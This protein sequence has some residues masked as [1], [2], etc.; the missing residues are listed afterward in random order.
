MKKWM[1]ITLMSAA[2]MA[3][4][5]LSGCDSSTNANQSKVKTHIITAKKT[6]TTSNLYYKGTIEPINIISA[7]SPV[8]GR[9]AKMGFAYGQ[10][11]SKGQ[12]LISINSQTLSQNFRTAISDYLTQKNS[13]E[14]QKVTYAGSQALYK[15]GVVQESSFLNDKTSYETA[16]M[17]YFQKKIA[18][19]KVLKQVGLQAKQFESLTLS[20]SQKV[21]KV[22]SKH[23]ADIPVYAPGS[24]VALFPI[25]QPNNSGSNDT[26]GE[27]LIVGSEVKQGQLI[28][29]IG[30][31]TGYTV[32]FKVSEI[33]V[34]RLH[35]GFKVTVT[36]AAFPGIK[37]KGVI[38]SVASQAM[39][40]S[41]A[42]V[43]Q[44]SVTVKIPK[45]S[46]KAQKNIHIGM[47][48]KVNIGIKNP[49]QIM[50]PIAA[51]SQVN[52]KSVVTIMQKD[53]SKK[54]VSVTTGQTT[55]TNVAILSGIQS[56]DKVVVDD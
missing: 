9:V 12:K 41:S 37:L 2:G 11:I 29:S 21:N 42:N 7:I 56:G 17:T 27:K 6:V 10:K 54:Q 26:N 40:G 30:D 4:L 19:E 8:E 36:G 1:S 55:L 24:G 22:L 25:A 28:L 15:A 33:D 48:A 35:K 20:N 39:K 34:N 14:N 51:V 18:L 50:L 13:L 32:S 52:G 16:L 49:A 44:F 3:V 45:V 47:T 23:F 5:M 43:S 53:G 38:T 46:A 31:L